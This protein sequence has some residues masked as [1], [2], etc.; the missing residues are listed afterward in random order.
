MP[1]AR[2]TS[3]TPSLETRLLGPGEPP[4]VE[5]VNPKGHAPV[6][7]LCDHASPRIPRALGT[8]GLDEAA[9]KRHIAWD[10]G[11]AEV[12]RHIA[13]HLDAPALLAGYSRLVIDLNRATDDP[14]SIV[15]ASDG[16]P[17]PGNRNLP[18]AEAALRREALFDAYHDRVAAA[19][20]RFLAQGRVPAIVSMH[21]FTPVMDGFERPWHV[22]V[23]W[24][25]DE[26]IACP[27]LDRLGADPGLCV[28]DNQ[29]YSAH[30]A[31][32]HSMRVHGSSR[33]LAN[34]LIELRQDLIDTHRGAADW[35]LRLAG[36]LRHIL[37][38]PE[39]F[40]IREPQPGGE[41]RCP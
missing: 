11:A 36:E 17:I 14:T 23:L 15:E 41:S 40:R 20:D 18:E 32:G 35:A 39:V 30:Q 21:S 6:L 28:G 26:R 10:I 8:L 2:A 13:V 24:A 27:L 34:V 37:A 29:P 3:R 25:E 4:P 5:P 16:T 33:G 1:D 12:T 31:Q 22:G 7:L 38:D 19:I 9:L